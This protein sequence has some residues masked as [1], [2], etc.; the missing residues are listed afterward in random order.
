MFGIPRIQDSNNFIVQRHLK[1][2][3]PMTQVYFALFKA[4]TSTSHSFKCLLYIFV[5]FVSATETETG[6]ISNSVKLFWSKRE[7]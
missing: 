7:A 5:A 1:T 2:F 4:K 6:V 3:K